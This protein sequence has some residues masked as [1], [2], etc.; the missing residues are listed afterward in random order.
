MT[1]PA[2]TELLKLIDE[3]EKYSREALAAS[4]REW[5]GKVANALRQAASVERADRDSAFEIMRRALE[6]IANLPPVLLPAQLVDRFI[7]VR[8]KARAALPVSVE[9]AQPVR[10]TGDIITVKVPDGYDSVADF[11]DD[12]GLEAVYPVERADTSKLG[13]SEPLGPQYDGTTMDNQ[14]LHAGPGGGM[15]PAH[16]NVERAEVAGE[17][18]GWN[19]AIEAAAKRAEAEPHDENE[20]DA[21]TI[22]RCIAL[23]IRALASPPRSEGV[24]AS[25]V[26]SDEGVLA[27]ADKLERRFGLGQPTLRY[28]EVPVVIATLRASAQAVQEPPLAKLLKEV[29]PGL[30]D[31]LT[32]NAAWVALIRNNVVTACAN[33]AAS[34]SPSDYTADGMRNGIVAAIKGLAHPS[35]QSGGAAD[36]E[37]PR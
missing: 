35:A 19:A 21:I 6:D 1:A 9:R 16:H 27:L 10:P 34:H 3:A 4:N 5:Y 25:E 12:C 8:V 28:E 7:E 14:Q 22:S 13:S 24:R 29:D 30:A 20:H 18:A 36:Q 2:P 37:P 17:A 11:L 32:D 33:V 23:G 26:R 31:V 15:T